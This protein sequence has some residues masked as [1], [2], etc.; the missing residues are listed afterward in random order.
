M[1]IKGGNVSDDSFLHRV[2]KP[3]K[4]HRNLLPL[5][6][7]LGCH[8]T[9]KFTS[10]DGAERL[11]NSVS[12]LLLSACKSAT[13]RTW[14]LLTVRIYEK[15]IDPDW[16]REQNGHT[17]SYDENVQRMGLAGVQSLIL[18]HRDDFHRRISRRNS[19]VLD[20]FSR[21]VDEATPAVVASREN[22]STN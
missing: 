18:C 13:A 9:G 19:A 10:A 20:N 4:G 16:S 6:Q 15:K 12:H 21:F 8:L 11:P 1:R 5:E 3:R 17:C 2:T 7:V 14:C 22:T